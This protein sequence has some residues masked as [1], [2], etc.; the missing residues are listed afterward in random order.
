MAAVLVARKS[1]KLVVWEFHVGHAVVSP[2]SSRWETTE[3]EF[4]QLDGDE[5]EHAINNCGAPRINKRVVYYFGDMA[6]QIYFNW[7]RA[8]RL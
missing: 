3:I 8:C 4:I 6:K 5:L 1:D 2:W 7:S